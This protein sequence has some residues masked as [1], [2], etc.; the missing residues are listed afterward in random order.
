VIE[1]GAEVCQAGFNVA[2]AFAPSQLSEGQH[3]G[4][5]INRQF[6]D[7]EV[8]AA[9]GDTPVKFVLGN[10]VEELDEDGATFVH[11]VENHRNG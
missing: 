3:K 4:M 11:K 6:A 10:E 7:T 1:F 9:T 2:Q 8:A 5:F